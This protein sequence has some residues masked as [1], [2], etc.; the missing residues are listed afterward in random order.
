MHACWT[1]CFDYNHKGNETEIYTDCNILN[2]FVFRNQNLVLYTQIQYNKLVSNFL[3]IL[4]FLFILFFAGG[5][6]LSTNW[7]EVGSQ[8]VGV[9][10]PSGTDF[11]PWSE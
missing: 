4:R 1:L 10:P 5:T 2:N 9:K 8:T 7:N 3:S 6:V 11:V